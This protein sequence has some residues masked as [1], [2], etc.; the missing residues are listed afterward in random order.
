ML[1]MIGYLLYLIHISQIIIIFS[2][3][4]KVVL[5]GFKNVL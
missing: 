4:T 2:T 1:V 3:C 5:I